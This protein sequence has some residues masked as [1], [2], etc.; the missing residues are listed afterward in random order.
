MSAPKQR[1]SKV[2]FSFSVCQQP[3]HEGKYF[4][5]HG[6]NVVLCPRKQKKRKER[7]ATIFAATVACLPASHPHSQL[8]HHE[9]THPA[10]K[11]ANWSISFSG[12][13]GTGPSNATKQRATVL[14]HFPSERPTGLQ[15]LITRHCQFEACQGLHHTSIFIAFC[16]NFLPLY[17]HDT[18]PGPTGGLHFSF[19]DCQR[20]GQ[21]MK[22]KTN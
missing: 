8:V 9:T 15:T 13:T 2:Q 12:A 16:S 6:L 14:H 1:L 7:L 5:G 22:R 19:R 20:K 21:R 4:Q 3:K 11:Q 17:H 18:N 10:S